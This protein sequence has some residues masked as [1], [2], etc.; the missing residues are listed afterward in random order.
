MAL[1]CDHPLTMAS[2]KTRADH[3]FAALDASAWPR[4][5]CGDGAKG[6][7][8]YTTGRGFAPE[9]TEWM[10]ARRPISD[11]SELAF[12][13][14]WATRPVGL[15]ELVRVAGS[16]WSVEG[17]NVSFGWTSQPASQGSFYPQP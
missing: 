16:R 13:R 6:R 17:P 4:Y 5:C 15:P 14:C 7:R 9:G 1:S 2:A 11:P 10:L 8:F 3:A 12:Y